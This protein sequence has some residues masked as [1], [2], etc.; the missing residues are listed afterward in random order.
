MHF[1]VREKY[2]NCRSKIEL[3]CFTGENQAIP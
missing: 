1:Y 2:V 3:S